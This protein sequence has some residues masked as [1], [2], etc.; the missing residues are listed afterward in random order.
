MSSISQKL[1]SIRV[2]MT[3]WYAAMLLIGFV[4]LG[5]IMWI[6]VDAGIRSAT[7]Q[8][9]A[10]RLEGVVEPVVMESEHIRGRL[11]SIIGNPQ[12]AA[13]VIPEAAEIIAQLET[14]E[15]R[16]QFV[17]AKARD[18]A[19]SRMK[20]IS[21]LMPLGDFLEVRRIEGE[22]VAAPQAASDFPWPLESQEGAF[23]RV[24]YRDEPYLAHIQR[25]DI[26]G[27]AYRFFTATSLR[28]NRAVVE[29]MLVHL[30]WAALF[31]LLLS[32]I[33]GWAIASRALLPVD[34][35]TKTAQSISI[36]DLTHRLDTPQTGDE[37][38]R[39]TTT[40]NGMLARLENAVG[41]L[42]QFTADASHELRTPTAVIRTTAELALRRE[43]PPEEYREALRKIQG[44][45]GRM[46]QLVDELLTLAR[47]DSDLA[48]MTSAPVDLAATARDVCSDYHVLA[49]AR[50]LNFSW[51]LPDRTVTVD[52]NEDALRRLLVILLDNAFKYTKPGG[53]VVASLESGNGEAILAVEDT[54]VGIASE[55]L[56]RIFDR[57]Y[58]ADSSR[59]RAP[60]SFGLGLS[61]ANWIA[62]KHNVRIEVESKPGEG[63]TFR[64]RFQVRG[65]IAVPKDAAAA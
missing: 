37:L 57:F 22:V 16:E 49:E 31:F 2:R 43:R 35:I 53:K 1:R 3:L 17:R 61:M 54:G 29:Q 19:E 18:M 45:S 9:L 7:Q 62:K 58:R 25:F 34:Q 55:D 30:Q 15:E 27:D 33:G 41:Q 38:E 56:T 26:E 10:D 6:G 36:D 4:V 5:S 28:E 32:T 46:T 63:S 64:V 48:V 13:T 51:D 39:L 21:D 60:G 8:R 11:R 52:G 20:V 12:I 47:A 42:K 23:E 50:Q 44:E 40:W 14:E 24:D 59:T 65:P